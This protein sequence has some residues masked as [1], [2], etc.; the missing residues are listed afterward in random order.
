MRSL[1]CSPTCSTRAVYRLGVVLLAIG[2]MAGRA[3]AQTTVTLSTPGTHISVDTTIRDGAYASTNYSSSDSLVSKASGT[4]LK[5]RMLLKFDTE[6]YIPAN[7]VIQSARLYLVLK[8]ADTSEQR[9]LT[10]YRVTRSFT[11]P[12]S[13]WNYFRAGEAWTT[14]GGDVQGSFGT[15]WVGGGAGTTYTFDLTSLVQRSVNGEFGSRWT[16]VELIDTG[17]NSDGS[18]KA[19]HSTRAADASVRPRLVIVYGAAATPAPA[20]SPSTGTTLRVMQWNIQNARGSDGVCNPDRIAST[21]VR[22]N[23]DVV[24]MNEVKSFAGEC[25]WEFDMSQRLQSLLQSK[26][27]VT[28]YRKY[29]SIGSK[30]GNA[31]LSRYPLVSSSTTLLSYDRG[32]AQIGIVVN[33]RTINLFSTHVEYY[34]AGW[35]TTQINQ[36]LAW[37]RNFPE[38]RILLA[39][40]NTPPATSD[41]WLVATPYQDAWVAAQNAGTASSFTGTGFTHGNSRFD[42]VFYSRVSAL[43]LKSVTVPDTRINGVYPSDHHPVVAVFEVN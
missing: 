19:F 37:I 31:L 39:D 28:W 30:A 27:G 3:S 8:S 34:N 33:G 25:S 18:Y 23:A 7:A 21:I 6:N 36:A 15:T 22:Q 32:V 12:D 26:T 40:M 29:V 17:A 42:Y 9:P 2:S 4:G 38:P 35:R 13:S 16:R 41:Y 43:T 11:K 1:V 20:P 10:A 14:P 5:R 24:G